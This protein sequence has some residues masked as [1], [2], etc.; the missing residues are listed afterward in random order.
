VAIPVGHEIASAPKCLAMTE[1]GMCLAMT[2]GGM[3]LA[4]TMGARQSER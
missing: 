2:E 4:M 3:C 1:G